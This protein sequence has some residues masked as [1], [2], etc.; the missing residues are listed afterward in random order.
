MVYLLERKSAF[1]LVLEKLARK[2]RCLRK[3][4]AI[5]PIQPIGVFFC[6]AHERKS[7]ITR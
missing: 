3:E 7:Q 5:A 2:T 4:I 6:L 1:K